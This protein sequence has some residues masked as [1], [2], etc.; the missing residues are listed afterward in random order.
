MTRY[1]VLLVEDELSM[2]LGMQHA[3]SQTGYEVATAAE[4]ETAC[5]LLQ[6]RPF[7]LASPT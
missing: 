2:R 3:L 4:A 1:S 5:Q 6:E 7:D